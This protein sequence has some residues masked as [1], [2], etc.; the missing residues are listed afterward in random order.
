[1]VMLVFSI[2]GICSFRKPLSTPVY[3]TLLSIESFFSFFFI[4]VKSKT[5]IGIPFLISFQLIKK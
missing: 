3:I 1:M 4:L 2:M 5:Q